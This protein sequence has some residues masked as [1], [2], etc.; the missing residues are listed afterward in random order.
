MKRCSPFFVGGSLALAAQLVIAGC[1]GGYRLITLSD[2]EY[3]KCWQSKPGAGITVSAS[4]QPLYETGNTPAYEAS[5][6]QSIGMF[7]VKIENNGARPVR[8]DTAH[9]M[10][11]DGSGNPAR[12]I[13]NPEAAAKLLGQGQALRGDLASNPLAG[14]TLESGKSYAAFICVTA[15][16]DP[17]F[18]TY[19][20]RFLGE[21]GEVVTEARF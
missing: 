14:N 13:R 9:L 17:Y 20:L 12:I 3:K 18:A 10:V 15:Q 2:L 11:L 7:A 4:K 6:K 5:V 16:G 1:A 21:D 19:Y 8:T